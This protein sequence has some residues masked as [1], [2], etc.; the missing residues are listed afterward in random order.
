MLGSY[1]QNDSNTY[2]A[3]MRNAIAIPHETRSSSP[4][5]VPQNWGRGAYD[6]T[7]VPRPVKPIPSSIGTGY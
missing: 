6:V 2:T 5:T 7:L 1:R 4:S 3:T